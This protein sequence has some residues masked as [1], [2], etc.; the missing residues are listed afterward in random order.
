MSNQWD[1][2]PKGSAIQKWQSN[3]MIMPQFT[4]ANNSVPVLGVR[5]TN[6]TT[7]TAHIGD[8]SQPENYING[9]VY[10]AAKRSAYNAQ[11]SD[12][13][14]KTPLPAGVP[15]ASDTV[16][17]RGSNALVYVRENPELVIGGLLVI[18][19]VMYLYRR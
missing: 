11:S 16:I 9:S 1:S 14:A 8:T 2:Y 17:Q 13:E 5:T 3:P 19:V 18:M 4:K 15:N 12:P 7:Y 10:E 6:N